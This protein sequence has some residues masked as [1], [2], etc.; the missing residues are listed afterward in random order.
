MEILTGISVSRSR[1]K[2]KRRE[3]PQTLIWTVICC[4]ARAAH[5]C[6]D[7][8]SI[9][10]GT[11]RT[12][13]TRFWKCVFVFFNQRSKGLHIAGLPVENA[14]SCHSLGRSSAGHASLEANLCGGGEDRP[15]GRASKS[16]NAL[17]YARELARGTAPGW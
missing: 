7:G 6:Q 2:R 12:R 3:S 4:P 15:F 1:S 5:Y 9:I 13:I 8:E 14:G 10:A 17:V 16:A 11:S